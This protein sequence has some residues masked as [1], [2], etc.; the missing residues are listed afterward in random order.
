MKR[1][2]GLTLGAAAA[3][4]LAAFTSSSRA[5]TCAT[6]NAGLKLASGFCATLFADS[7]GLPRHMVIAPNGDLFVAIRSSGTDTGG[8]VVLRDNDGDGRA[9][10]RAKFGK[11]NATEV[12]L[13]G[14]TLYTENTTSILRYHV[15]GNALAP[16]GAPDTIVTG[17]PAEKG[18][19][20]K[21]FLIYKGQLYVNHGSLTNSC[22]EKDRG[23]RSPGIDPC[24]ELD[25]RAGIW[26]YSAE[27]KGQTPSSGEHFA[28]GI[29]NAVAMAIE[30]KSN[31]LYVMQHGRDQLAQNWGFTNEQSAENPAEELFHVTRR[32]DF[33]WPYCYFDPQ[34]KKKVLAPEYGGDGKAVGRCAGK[35]GNVGYFPAHWAPNGLLFYTGARLPRRYRDG[36]FIV[37]H[38]SWNRAPL[39]AGGYKVVFQP[40][41]KGRAVGNFETVVE[42]FIDAEG[43]PTA[44]GGRPMGIAQGRSGELYLSDDGKGR[45]W[46]IEYVGERK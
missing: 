29:R 28:R 36:A 16:T 25:E 15:T 26:R 42:G 24:T 18:H 14:N 10:R 41:A 3:L 34:Q 32:A 22:Q 43:K 4:S 35:Q 19:V 44:L 27:K 1:L 11:F 2:T 20:A 12:R 30:P 39:P 38:G 33:G 8:V 40:M 7:L 37:F 9:D 45:I 17:L 6:D 5:P 13:L 31:A 21:T 46:R 23:D